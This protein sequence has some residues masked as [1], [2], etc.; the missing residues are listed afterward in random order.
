MAQHIV[1]PFG[2]INGVT[3]RAMVRLHRFLGIG[4]NDPR[5]TF[6][7]AVF[8]VPGE[9][10][11]EDTAGN[12]LHV[13]LIALV[14]LFLLAT[15]QLR[16][17]R[18]LLFYAAALV[19]QF[20]IFSL[21]LKWQP[22]GS[23]L[24][25]PM[26]VLWTP[27]I[28]AV[29]LR[30]LGKKIGFSIACLLLLLA[31]P[32]VLWNSVRPLTAWTAGDV[33]RGRRVP[34]LHDIW[35]VGRTA[36]YFS[37]RRDLLDSYVNAAGVVKSTDCTSVGLYMGENDYEYPLWVLLRAGDSRTLRIEHVDVDAAWGGTAYPLG[38]FQPDVI[39]RTDSEFGRELTVG[40]DVYIQQ[41]SAGPLSVLVKETGANSG[42]NR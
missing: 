9:S 4:M 32:Y 27:L 40:R 21:M 23:R 30:A 25:L 14:V 18:V 37:N 16:A 31:A 39:I 15:P 8:R 2:G 10:F 41:W 36:Q 6:R 11:H 33:L 35:H 29:T 19:S 20:L 38:Q 42:A 28:G 22:W 17:H 34:S 3:V 7:D 12:P 5:T 24:Q 1:T 26:F 13:L